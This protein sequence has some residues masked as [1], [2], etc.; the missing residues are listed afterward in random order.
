LFNPLPQDENYDHI[1][2]A[3]PE[4][5]FTAERIEILIQLLNKNSIPYI[6][7]EKDKNKKI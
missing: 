6:K 5:D 2:F 1:S 4:S 3:T 7:I